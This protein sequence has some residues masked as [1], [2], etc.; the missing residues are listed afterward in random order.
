MTN[1]TEYLILMLAKLLNAIDRKNKGISTAFRL[2][3]FE[4]EISEMTDEIFK[5]PIVVKNAHNVMKV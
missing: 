1:D 4:S 5:H 3:D 2:P